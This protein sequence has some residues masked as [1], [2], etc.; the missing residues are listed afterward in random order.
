MVLSAS[1]YL[2]DETII[3]HIPW[4]SVDEVD[5][6]LKRKADADVERYRAQQEELDAMKEGEMK[7][8][9]PPKEDVVNEN[10]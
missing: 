8:E 6:I 9:T 3:K 2:D 4:I 1:A 10:A 5:E 7:Q